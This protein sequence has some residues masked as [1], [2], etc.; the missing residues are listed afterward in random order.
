MKADSERG[1]PGFA[2]LNRL[3]GKADRLGSEMYGI[4]LDHGYE[5]AASLVRHCTLRLGAWNMAQRGRRR[6]QG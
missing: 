5:S 3:F 2:V 1:W 4:R 6:D